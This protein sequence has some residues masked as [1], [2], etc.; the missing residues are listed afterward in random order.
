M[1]KLLPAILLAVAG[2]QYTE[3]PTIGP[4]PEPTDQDGSSDISLDDGACQCLS[5][6]GKQGN[7]GRDGKD[8]I[9]GQDG[10]DGAQGAQGPKGDPGEQGPQGV[11]GMSIVGPPG[12]Q[13]PMGIG[14]PGAQGENGLASLIRATKRCACVKFE[15]ALDTNANY[16]VEDEEVVQT[17]EMCPPGVEP[18]QE[19]EEDESEGDQ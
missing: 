8:G 9:D 11:P 12:P 18:M 6:P 16:L 19:D 7:P 17:I 4:S 2:C 1:L 14:R 15:I 13:G 10:Q 3:E 5:R